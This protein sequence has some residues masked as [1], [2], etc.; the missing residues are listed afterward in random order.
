MRY[1]EG[2]RWG[3]DPAD[4]RALDAWITQAPENDED[5]CLA[6]G[7]EEPC[8]ACAGCERREREAAEEYGDEHEE[9]LVF[10]LTREP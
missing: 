5:D 8:R 10:G 1:D 3:D 6:M 9:P 4:L 2:Y 7:A